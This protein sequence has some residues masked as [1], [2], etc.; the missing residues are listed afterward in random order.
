[1]ILLFTWVLH[2][3]GWGQHVII[4]EDF[5]FYWPVQ[6]YDIEGDWELEYPYY[7]TGPSQSVNAVVGRS[8][9]LKG[10]FTLNI[11]NV[12]VYD[13]VRV[14]AIY[15]NYNGYYD[16]WNNPTPY[17]LQISVDNLNWEA[18]AADSYE[19]GYTWSTVINTQ[20]YPY[21]RFH[22]PYESNLDNLL[23]IGYSDNQTSDNCCFDVDQN[24]NIG[25]QDL[26]AFLEV[27]GTFVN[28]D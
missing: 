25:A 14:E 28:C 1:M 27:Y 17:G 15:F 6:Q 9:S 19:N 5:E 20:D 24:G 22:T 26:L 2:V 23:V 21:V 4:K 12:N 7:T 10:P 3:N 8:R 13:S 16:Y 18:L 11:P